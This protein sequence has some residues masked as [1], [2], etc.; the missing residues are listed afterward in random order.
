M[1]FNGVSV[2]FP[3]PPLDIISRVC[4]TNGSS[5]KN[6]EGVGIMRVIHMREKLKKIPIPGLRNLKTALAVTIC[7]LLYR[8]TGREGVTMALIAAVLCMQGTMDKSVRQGAERIR[9]TILGGVMGAVFAL[10]RVPELPL[11]VFLLITF[12]GVVLFIYLCNLLRSKS[13]IVIGC[14]VF[15]STLAN[16]TGTD[17][18]LRYPLDRTLDTLTGIVIAFLVNRLVFRPRPERDIGQASVNPAFHYKIIRAKNQKVAHWYGGETSELYIY[19]EDAVFTDQDFDFRVSIS[20][21]GL[22]HNVF[23]RFPGYKRHTMLLAGQAHIF[24]KGHYEVDLGPY[25]TDCFKG[26]WATEV[27]GQSVDFNLITG[28]GYAGGL[29]PCLSEMPF[30][31]KNDRYAAFYS[32]ADGVKLTLENAGREYVEPMGKGDYLMVTWYENGQE[33]YSVTVDKAGTPPDQVLAVKAE[34]AREA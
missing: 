10:L 21:V 27:T 14:V 31:L 18:A 15:L 34:C 29:E 12:L 19:P 20:T 2:D 3:L 28:E 1:D 6:P 25:G 23:A 8:I 4:Y 7:M 22:A 32:M 5:G 13:S 24:H 17:M 9:G 33:S 30:H 11:P 16:Y 26:D